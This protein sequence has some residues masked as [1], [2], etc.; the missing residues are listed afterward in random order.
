[1][2]VSEYYNG[3][4]KYTI[5]AQEHEKIDQALRTSKS[6]EEAAEKL[7]IN[8]NTLLMRLKRNDYR[9]G[10]ILYLEKINK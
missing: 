8:Q 4:K 1:M 7:G 6:T 3:M 9:V 2:I 5:D 10:R